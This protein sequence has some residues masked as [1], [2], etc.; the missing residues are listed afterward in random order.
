MKV[1]VVGATGLADNA[2]GAV[3]V[4]VQGGS[5]WTQQAEI[6]ASDPTQGDSFGFAVSLSGG[7]L[8]VSAPQH[9]VDGDI[10]GVAYLFTQSGN[11]WTEL[12]ELEASDGATGE[13]FGSTVSVNG[14]VVVV[15]D[16]CQV[17]GGRAVGAQQD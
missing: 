10:A 16:D 3:Y 4:F 2:G 11:T 17:V 6:R 7:T 12:A 5:T 8:A 15:G 13:F 1:A 9:I 14:N